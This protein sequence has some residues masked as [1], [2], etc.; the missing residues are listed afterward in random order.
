MSMREKYTKPTA[1]IYYYL[2]EWDPATLSWADFREKVLGATDPA[3]AADGALRKKIYEGWEGLGLP[4]EPNVGDNGMHASASPFEALAER[5]NWMGAS[6]EEDAFGAAMLAAGI[7]KETIMAWTKDPQVPFE[8]KKCSLF[9]MLEDLD[10]DECLAKAQAIAGVGGSRPAGKMQAFVFVKP[11]AVTDATKALAKEHLAEAGITVYKEGELTGTQ[12]EEG[13][14]IDNHYYAIAAKASLSKPAEL[15]PPEKAQAKFEETF[16][17]S[18]PAALEA[19]LVYNAVDG[20]AQLGIDGDQM[21]ELWAASKK[22]GNLVKF[23]G[24]FYAGQISSAL[25]AE[26][27]QPPPPKA[28]DKP[29]I[30]KMLLTAGRA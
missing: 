18:W 3:T 2:V 12:I 17:I 7:P 10:Y 16:G 15:N 9:D 29:A 30:Q 27:F 23:G 4:S 25:W 19:G 1:S 6:L 22:A 5:L 14:L 20:C 26:L 28:S 8:G 13:M 11:H 24:G 21:N